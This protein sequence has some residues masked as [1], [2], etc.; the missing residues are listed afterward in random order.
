MAGRIDSKWQSQDEERK[1]KIVTF[2]SAYFHPSPHSL[3]F[4]SYLSYSYSHDFMILISHPL[5]SRALLTVVPLRPRQKELQ[6]SWSMQ[7]SGGLRAHSH[8]VSVRKV[9]GDVLSAPELHPS[10]PVCTRMYDNTVSIFC[11]LMVH[12]ASICTL[13]DHTVSMCRHCFAHRLMAY[14][15]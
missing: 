9:A 8:W 13:M 7:N 5:F 6:E 14:D 10:I 11:T 3:P 1:L 4:L 2:F 12:A 15:V